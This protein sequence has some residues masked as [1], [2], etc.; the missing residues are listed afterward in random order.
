MSNIYEKIG[1][2]TIIN[3]KGPATRLSGGVMAEEDSKAMQE[4]TQYC[5]DMVKL[6][7]IMINFIFAKNI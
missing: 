4:A 5:I 7:N 1:V 2:P 3:A 6:I